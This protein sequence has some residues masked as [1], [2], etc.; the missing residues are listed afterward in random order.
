MVGVAVGGGVAVAV[1]V[2]VM[3]GRL[4]GESVVVKMTVFKGL[5]RPAEGFHAPIWY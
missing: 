1:G 5:G 2:R 4:S 3:V